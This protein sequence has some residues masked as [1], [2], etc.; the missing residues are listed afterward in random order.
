MHAEIE[1]KQLRREVLAVRESMPEQ[2]WQEK[3]KQIEAALMKHPVFQN[4]EYILSYVNYKKEVETVSL[5]EKALA[6]GKHVFCPCVSGKTMDFY[7]IFSLEELKDGYRGI[8]EPE[9]RDAE[10][11]FFMSK[12]GRCLMIMPGAVF[13]KKLHRIGY[14]GGYYDRYLAEIFPEEQGKQRNSA[15]PDFFAAAVAFSFQVKNEIPY[16]PHD[17]CPQMIV[18]EKGILGLG[19]I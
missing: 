2:E 1:K 16:A 12:K 17:I 15:T 5:I 18:T 3:S 11:R 14:G 6:M 10:R 13:D 9:I 7:E 19:G 8:S 4:A